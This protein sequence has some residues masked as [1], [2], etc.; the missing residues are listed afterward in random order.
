MNLNN[1]SILALAALFL[2]F[3]A[4]TE[5]KKSARP[6]GKPQTFTALTLEPRRATIYSDYPATIEG[7]EIVQLR[8]MVDGY[9]EQI[10]VPEGAEVKKGQLL[11]RIQNPVY[12]EAVVTAKAA[13]QSAQA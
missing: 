3:A 10:F 12:D 11:F 13:I 7:I 1:R 4:C 8:P 9:L 5:D 6:P 2:V